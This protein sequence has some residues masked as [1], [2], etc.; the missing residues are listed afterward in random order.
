VALEIHVRSAI[1]SGDI[2]ADEM[3]EFAVHFAHY[4]GWP[5]SSTLYGTI[6]KVLAEDQE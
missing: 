5:L 2:S 4:G 1:K 3:M 6:R